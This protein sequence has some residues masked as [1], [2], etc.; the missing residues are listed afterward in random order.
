MLPTTEEE[1]FFNEFKGD[2]A[3]LDK[4]DRYIKKVMEIPRAKERLK[5]IEFIL[6]YS[7]YISIINQ[8]NKIFHKEFL[9]VNIFF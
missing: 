5:F 3:E 4:P 7:T 2:I 1:P 9:L 6:K 8:V